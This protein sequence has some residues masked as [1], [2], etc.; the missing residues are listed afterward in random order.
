MYFEFVKS[1]FYFSIILINAVTI[2]GLGLI[3]L[4]PIRSELVYLLL[5]STMVIALYWLTLSTTRWIIATQKGVL[6]RQLLPPALMA[7]SIRD[8]RIMKIYK[9]RKSTY[10]W[11]FFVFIT[12]SL[13]TIFFVNLITI[14]IVQ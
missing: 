9:F 2:F 5:I 6:T 7:Y 8:K 4:D 12:T 13:L 1:Q 10:R 3:G 14:S 11:D